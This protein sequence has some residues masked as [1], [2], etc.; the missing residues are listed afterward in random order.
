MKGTTGLLLENQTKIVRKKPS[1]IGIETESN[2]KTGP[3]SRVKEACREV[4]CRGKKEAGDK[5][6]AGGEIRQTG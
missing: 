5:E 2:Q 3:Q 6:K 1:Q 4:P